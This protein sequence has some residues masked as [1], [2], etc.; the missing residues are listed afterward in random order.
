[1][2]LAGVP[3]RTRCEIERRL[4]EQFAT[5]ARQYAEAVVALT[6]QIALSQ[7]EYSRLRDAT[8]TARQQVHSI[9]ARYEE[10]VESHRC[11]EPARPGGQ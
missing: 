7:S 10:H 5:A 11:A 6:V 3:T 1:M 4:A 2:S 9:G 8:R